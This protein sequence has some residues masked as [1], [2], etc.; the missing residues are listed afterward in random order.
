[1][2][3]LQEAGFEE[4][5]RYKIIIKSA[6]DRSVVPT[7]GYSFSELLRNKKKVLKLREYR[8]EINS[9]ITE[10]TMLRARIMGTQIMKDAAKELQQQGNLASIPQTKGELDAL[11][12]RENK[13]HHV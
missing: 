11:V 7:T 9:E 8:D 4:Q 12:P 10:E 13:E 6:I 2:Q 3:N 5:E 1:M